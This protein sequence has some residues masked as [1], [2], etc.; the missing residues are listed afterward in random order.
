M[1]YTRHT[2]PCKGLHSKTMAQLGSKKGSVTST[3]KKEQKTPSFIPVVIFPKTGKC[4]LLSVELQLLSCIPALLL[5]KRRAGMLRSEKEWHTLWWWTLVASCV[6]LSTYKTHMLPT[7]TLENIFFQSKNTYT[8]NKI[9]L[10]ELLLCLK[11]HLQRI[12][13]VDSFL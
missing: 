11:Q 7:Q 4:H 3:S 9:K 12:I 5:C 8:G 1:I 2:A 10:L 13:Q 6:W